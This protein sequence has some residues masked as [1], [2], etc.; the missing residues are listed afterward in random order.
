MSSIESRIGKDFIM[1]RIKGLEK[2]YVEAL[3]LFVT[4]F[5]LEEG[6][7]LLL[8]AVGGAINK[9]VT[10]DIDLFI[11]LDGGD[12]NL[13]KEWKNLIRGGIE[14]RF[15][16]YLKRRFIESGLS[17]Y[18]AVMS[19][20][21]VEMFTQATV[22]CWWIPRRPEKEI[23]GVGERPIHLIAFVTNGADLMGGL[24]YREGRRNIILVQR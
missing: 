15:W 1:E 10:K 16:S 9:P 5:P 6:E 24:D 3:V 2:E 13:K 11:C 18:G 23:M 4:D 21:I 8:A 14:K 7:H 12:F 20:E 17:R 22:N 19:T